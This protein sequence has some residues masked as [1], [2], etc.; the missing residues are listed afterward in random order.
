MTRNKFSQLFGALS[1]SAFGIFA[2]NAGGLAIAGEVANAGELA[3]AGELQAS[4]DY[5]VKNGVLLAPNG[6]EVTL[7]G[8][9]YSLP[10]AFGYRSVAELGLDHREAIAMDVA[11]LARLGVTAYR[12]HLWDKLLTDRDGNLLNNE[13]LALF[14]FL[15]QQLRQHHIKVIITPIAWWGSGYPAPDPAEPGFAV[16][17]SK[18]QMNEQPKAIAAQHRYLQQL[19]AH[20]NLDG[21]SYAKDPNIVAFELFNEPKHAKAEPV[22]DYVNQLIAT[23]RAAGVTKPLFYNISE[24]GNW[25]EFADA[26]C[27]SNIDGIAYQWY[28]TGLLK[29]SSIHSNVLGS[30]ASYHNPFADIA[31]CQTKAKM[32]YE[33]DA[34]DVAQTVMYPAMA[35]SFRSAGF[36]WATQFAYD[37]AALAASNAEYNTHY[38]NLLYTPGKAISLLI[39]GEVFRQTPRQAKQPAYPASNQFAHGSLQVLLNQAEDLALLDSGDKFYHS[40]STTTAPKQPKQVAHIAG[41]G[42]SPL[43]Q[44]QGSGAYFLDQISPDLWQLEVYPDVLTLQDPFQSSSLK[45][46]VA[47]LYA[48]NRTMTI[49]LASLGQQFYW[50]KVADGKSAAESSAQQQKP[51]Q[52]QQGQIQLT[53]GRYLLAKTAQLLDS[54]QGNQLAANFQLPALKPTPM[55]LQHQPLRQ[56]SIAEPLPVCAQLGSNNNAEVTLYWRMLGEKNFQSKP[57]PATD[58]A[59]YCAKLTARELSQ[60]GQLQYVISAKSKDANSSELLT[61]PQGIAS[62]PTDWDYPLQAADEGHLYLTQLQQPGAMIPLFSA[63]HDSTQ[64]LYPKA[65]QVSQSWVAGDRQQGLAL[66][67]QLGA[68]ADPSL[69][70]TE[71]NPDLAL[72]KRDFSGYDKVAIKIRALKEPLELS[73]ALLNSDGL[74][75]GTELTVNSKWQYL[76]VPLSALKPMPTELT[77]A[78]PTFMPAQ[79]PHQATELGDVAKLQGLQL[80]LLASPTSTVAVELAEVSLLKSQ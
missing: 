20:K 56:W 14:D 41:V 2:A 44:Y 15:L 23:M 27:A 37:P 36:Q 9:N 31:K 40:N 72:A 55:Q 33:F 60:S 8:V 70:R 28:P 61:F 7:F 78:Y 24:Q 59:S 73:F 79:L 57:M 64:L 4:S 65:S 25:P 11:H 12:V 54:Q 74:A 63:N 1:L 76:V 32:I 21:V 13:H 35:R 17:Y 77:Q 67:L 52:A 68:K 30:V 10:F 43:V 46:Q 42:S 69:V 29:N 71:I 47:T 50:R 5:H 3:I 66:R 51:A 80:R 38:L 18:N 22:T 48:P 34:A 45:R 53:P 39:A 49:D 62:T 16:P 58:K 6:E 26:L 75:F 19:M